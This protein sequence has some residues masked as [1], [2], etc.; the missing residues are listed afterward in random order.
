MHGAAAALYGAGMTLN[1]A[2]DARDDRAKHPERPIPSGAVSAAAAFAQGGALVAIAL[3]LA[4]AAGPRPGLAAALLA[5]AILL[6]DGFLKRWAVPGAIAMGACRYL[7]VQLGAGFAAGAALPPALA[8]G[9]YVALLTFISTFE[10]RPGADRARRARLT[11]RLLLGIFL[12]DGASLA[13]AGRPALGAA[14]AALALSVPALARL[15]S[16]LT[17]ASAGG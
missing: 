9:A 3:A 10:D 17:R 2:F 1:D 15:Q 16:R 7:D 4:F 12:V 6:Y 5:G 13:I 8:L 14:A 11:F